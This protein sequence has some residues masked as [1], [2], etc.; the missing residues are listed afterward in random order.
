MIY[1]N[2]ILEIAREN[3]GIVTTKQITENKIARIYLTKLVQKKN[4]E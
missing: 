2:K 4:I 3:N 1:E